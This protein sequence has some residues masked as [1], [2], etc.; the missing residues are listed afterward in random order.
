[1]RAW[2]AMTMGA[3]GLLGA[4]LAPIQAQTPAGPFVDIDFNSA[5]DG[6]VR[7]RSPNGHVGRLSGNATLCEGADGYAV[8][9]PGG[10]SC[11]NIDVAEKYRAL[12]ALTI[13]CWLSPEEVAH[14][15]VVTAAN[16]LDSFDSLPFM[17]R[18][19]AN[20][21]FMFEVTTAD[22]ERRVITAPKPCLD[23]ISYP[24]RNWVH[25]VA[26]YD[27]AKSALYVD[28]EL[29]ASQDWPKGKKGLLKIN[30]PLKLGGHGG[31][32]KGAIDNLKVY[33]RALDAAEVKAEFGLKKSFTS[34][35]PPKEFAGTI[36]GGRYISCGRAGENWFVMP[37][38][39][40]ALQLTSIGECKVWG[41]SRN[42]ASHQWDTT[43]PISLADQSGLRDMFYREVS[44][45]IEL[46]ADGTS[47]FELTGAATSGLGV[48]QTIE[49]TPEDEAK[50]H[51]ELSASNPRTPRPALTWAQHLWPSAL[52]FVGSDEQGLITGNLMD[53]DGE[54]WFRNLVE[55]NLISAD[56]T[57]G[58]ETWTG[59]AI[60]CHP[61]RGTRGTGSKAGATSSARSC[62]TRLGIGPQLKPRLSSSPS[63]WSRTT[64]RRAWSAPKPRRVTAN[65][66]FDFSRLY[67]AD[68]TRLSLL[69]VGRDI[70][71]FM[72]DENVAFSVETP[73]PLLTAIKTY[74]W[75]LTDANTKALVR[76]GQLIHCNP[77]WEWTGKLTFPAPAP[78]PYMLK[79]Q[80]LDMDKKVVSEC[81]SEVIVAGEI[82][83]PMIKPGEPLKLKKV[84]EVDL[85]AEKPGHD[86]YSFSGQS[87]VVKG[88]KGSWR[89]TLSFKD[90]QT[91]LSN[92]GAASWW[93]ND[94]FGARFKTEPG[95]IYVVEMEY[96][97]IEFMSVSTYFME[98]KDDPADGKC[99]PAL[100]TTSGL[101]TGTFV[102]CDGAMKTFQTVHF[103]SAPWVAVCV[104]N[105]HS[106]RPNGKDLAPACFK[107]FTLYEIVGDLPKLDAPADGNRL[108]G[109]HCESGGLAMSPFGLRKFRGELGNWLD[110]PAPGEYY[111]EAYQ[112]VTN[113]VKYMRYRG[114]TTLFYGIYRYRGAQ[115]PSKTFPPSASE[116][117]SDL[118]GLVAR[119]FEKNGLKLVL[120]VMPNNPL[121]TS[122][123][124]EF[125]SYDVHHGASGVTPVNSEGTQSMLHHCLPASNPLHPK[126]REAYA[127]L[128]TEL[129]E[130]Y[131][132]YPA[133]AGMSWMTGQSWWE[134]CLPVMA[135]GN[136]TAE[137]NE[138]ALLGATCDD[139]TMRQFGQWAKVALPGKVDDPGRFK[140]R[141]D[142]IM[143]N[144]KEQFKDFRCWGM[145]QT[146]RAFQEAFA[147]K[148][149]G[150][151]YLAIDYLQ[152]IFVRKAE[153][154]PVEACRL[155]GSGPQVL[156]GHS[157]TCPLSLCARDQWLRP[158]GAQLHA[159]G[160]N[161]KDAE[162]RPG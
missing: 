46:R 14:K 74:A 107:R 31:L 38:K 109:V 45:N 4:C 58:D 19:R 124:Q 42:N 121:P 113:L 53:L 24:R 133:V 76:E 93:A 23:K 43:S 136:Q 132:K 91:F 82:P 44:G 20:W 12:D 117:D 126:V 62:P 160:I 131:G 157:R 52:R 141:F 3:M 81:Q 90:C 73:K 88:D 86:F 115:F 118:A 151:D 98:P 61:A 89:Q 146:H 122:R 56:A 49:V 13:S 155:F 104:Q 26:T 67:D 70:P 135:P 99:R 156:P 103:A 85:T 36:D 108:V 140:Q 11:V 119:M 79:L 125:S 147:K 65:V 143:A 60:S 95:K 159:V 129:G 27:G 75:E 84:D 37:L 161:A 64:S 153:W 1:M 150:K 8:R 78:G 7:D 116:A 162:V 83:Q 41:V 57:T 5:T 16:D 105:G 71:V 106:G 138:R 80:G 96:P 94:W 145:A 25:V 21:V 101:F 130:R 17:L 18:W 123:L 158:L 154:A 87:K 127:R 48:K 34:K 114:D 29:V 51:Y 2:K 28:G 142:W 47:R 55:I 77:F 152:D 100:R 68:M 110:T 35:A 66:P 59:H 32:F 39:H 69:P 22:R 33:D 92:M 30:H 54:L 10:A 50:F 139:E 112:T 9:L 15:E 40:G 72:D 63:N 111:R 102:P 134:P 149:P 97:D 120:N 144:A 128:A 148:A 6:A 137:E